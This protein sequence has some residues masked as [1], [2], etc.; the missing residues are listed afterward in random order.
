MA[1]FGLGY[2]LLLNM[3]VV[4]GIIASAAA[5]VLMLNI[6]YYSSDEYGGATHEERMAATCEDPQKS[7]FGTA[8]IWWFRVGVLR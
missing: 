3:L 8:G 6:N 4:L 1:G 5:A 2:V 7:R